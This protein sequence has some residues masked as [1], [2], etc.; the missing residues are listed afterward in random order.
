MVQSQLRYGRGLWAEPSKGCLGPT[1][2]ALH[3]RHS[4]SAK[5]CSWELLPFLILILVPGLGQLSTSPEASWP[6][7]RLQGSGSMYSLQS[8]KEKHTHR[9]MYTHTC[10]HMSTNTHRVWFS[11]F[12]LPHLLHSL[13]SSA[14]LNTTQVIP[15]QLNDHLES[16]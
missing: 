2:G 1:L 4:V 12:L 9:H 10:A 6:S 11:S 7:K 15:A 3:M 16:T 8:R 5:S 14:T 13:T